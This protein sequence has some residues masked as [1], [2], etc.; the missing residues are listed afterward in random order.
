MGPGLRR[1]PALGAPW[2]PRRHDDGPAAQP[3]TRPVARCGRLHASAE[4]ER[5]RGLW[6]TL[7]APRSR[8]PP[9]CVGPR[10]A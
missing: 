8:R 4:R 3:R 9:G 6:W 5:A 1:Q 2:A 7:L 10:G